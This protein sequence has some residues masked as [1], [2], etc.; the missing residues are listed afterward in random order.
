M[1]QSQPSL[2]SFP[3]PEPLTKP[4]QL[5]LTLPAAGSTAQPH[6]SV[7][8]STSTEDS[9]SGRNLYVLDQNPRKR[10]ACGELVVGEQQQQ[11]QPVVDQ[12]IRGWLECPVCNEIPREGFIFQ[13]NNG[14]CTVS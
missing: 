13:C 5:T 7:S 6:F 14:H 1:T 9:S 2:I 10:N 4:D 11:Q 3:Q 12:E 8:C